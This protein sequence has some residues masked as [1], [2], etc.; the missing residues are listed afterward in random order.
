MTH[1]HKHHCF[2]PNGNITLP[3]LMFF[4]L[5]LDIR[6]HEPIILHNAPSWNCNLLLGKSD[7]CNGEHARILKN[8]NIKVNQIY[9]SLNL[10]L[11]TRTQITLLPMSTERLSISP[12]LLFTKGQTQRGNNN[13]ATERKWS[14]KSESV[15]YGG[16]MDR[17]AMTFT[18]DVSL[19]KDSKQLCWWTNY[20]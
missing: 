6:R 15:K 4:S 14:S 10:D 7:K 20:G 8:K 1:S 17:G 3:S 9:Y 5:K 19:P 12:V 11:H 16:N 18:S 2:T 13:S